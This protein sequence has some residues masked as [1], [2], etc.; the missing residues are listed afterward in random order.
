MMLKQSALCLSMDMMDGSDIYFL[1]SQYHHLLLHS[2]CKDISLDLNEG[3]QSTC[4]DRNTLLFHYTV[5]KDNNESSM[6]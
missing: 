4:F 1:L 3:R 5:Q 6:L 2:E